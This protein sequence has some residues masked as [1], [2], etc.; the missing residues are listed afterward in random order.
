[1]AK[2]AYVGVGGKAR[3]VKEIYVGLEPPTGFSR[4]VVPVV[5]VGS[6]MSTGPMSQ[7]SV[8]TTDAQTWTEDK[9]PEQQWWTR[10]AYG[11]GR[12]IVVSG[13]SAASNVAAY[14]LVD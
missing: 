1:M 5:A 6:Q 3:K 9:L 11:D 13:Y 4:W 7:E 10:I 8:S 2:N 14:A 12:F